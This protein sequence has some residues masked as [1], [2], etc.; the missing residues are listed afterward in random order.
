MEQAAFSL[1]DRRK[2]SPKRPS[3]CVD[4]YENVCSVAWT[5]PRRRAI[6]HHLTLIV[7]N[8]MAMVLVQKGGPEAIPPKMRWLLHQGKGGDPGDPGDRGEG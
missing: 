1:E 3:L 6:H 5:T 7:A 8:S 2:A 4:R